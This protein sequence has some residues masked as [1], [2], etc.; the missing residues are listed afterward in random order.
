M[1]WVFRRDENQQNENQEMSIPSCVKL[2][3]SPIHD[4]LVRD[5][6]ST[7]RARSSSVAGHVASFAPSATSV[8]KRPALRS[9][10]RAGDFLTDRTYAKDVRARLALVR[11]RLSSR[12]ISL[13]A[14][15]H[16]PYISPADV[17]DRDL[18]RVHGAPFLA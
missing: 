16:F 7:S 14:R 2:A 6:T 15:L 12:Q 3:Q 13:G 17:P 9:R 1:D 4:V 18:R 5:A 10:L 8:L 11:P